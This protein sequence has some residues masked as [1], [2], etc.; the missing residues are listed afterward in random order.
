M[1]PFGISFCRIFFTVFYNIIVNIFVVHARI[2]NTRKVR[3]KNSENGS[4]NW[5]R[6][7]AN[8]ARYQR[9]ALPTELYHYNSQNQ[10]YFP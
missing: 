1:V 7:S 3:T 5:A 6:T 9:A 8:D 4:G 10:L 2:Y